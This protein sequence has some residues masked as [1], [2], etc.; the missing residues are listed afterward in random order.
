MKRKITKFQ[1]FKILCLIAYIGCVGVLIFE[2]CLDGKASASQ[3]NAVGGGIADILNGI[4]GDQTVAVK[5]TSLTIDNKDQYL[6]F[7]VGDTLTI[8]TTTTPADATY[9][10]VLY[11]TSDSSIAAIN[12]EGYVT[13]LQSGNVTLTVTNEKYAEIT[14]SVEI[15]VLN[16]LN[17]FIDRNPDSP[18]VRNSYRAVVRYW[19]TKSQIKAKYGKEISKSDLQELE[20]KWYDG[21]GAV[22][23]RTFGQI[24]SHE[25]TI[26]N[27]LPGY[28]D[29]EYS[30]MRNQLIPV[31]EVEWLETDKD[32]IMQ[33]YST[34]RI[35]ENI[36]ILRGKDEKVVRSKDNPAFCGLTVNGVYFLNRNQQPYSLILKCAHLQD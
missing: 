29:S 33:R 26:H 10:E 31:Y 12:D 35:G 4:N 11:S 21:E 19:M 13:F 28:P 18:Y 17:T 36:Y 22:Y 27:P 14:D 3:S 2:S 32:F 24:V 7:Y 34:I 20:D 9:K 15:E 16:P 30:T 25:E 23:R 6:T 1:L 5:P 8:T